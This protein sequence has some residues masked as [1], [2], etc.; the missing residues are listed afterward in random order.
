L[1]ACHILY[2]TGKGGRDTFAIT[3]DD[4]IE[5]IRVLM[6]SEDNL[7]VEAIGKAIAYYQSCMRVDSHDVAVGMLHRLLEGLGI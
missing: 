2:H 6:E 5:R 1:G 7:G 3:R 4:N